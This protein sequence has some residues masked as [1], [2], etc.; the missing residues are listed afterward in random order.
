MTSLNYRTLSN[1][2]G[3]AG[4]PGP[5]VHPQNYCQK[6]YLHPPS[7]ALVHWWFLFES[8]NYH[9]EDNYSQAGPAS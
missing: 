7:L 4:A 5:N 9:N 2:A 1:L 8:C 3:P 6:Q